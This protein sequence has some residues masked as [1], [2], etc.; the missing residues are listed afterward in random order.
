MCCYQ[1]EGRPPIP[2][3]PVP[4][5]GVSPIAPPSGSRAGSS[6]PWAPVTTTIVAATVLVFVASELLCYALPSYG[7]LLVSV[8]ANSPYRVVHDAWIWQLLSAGFMH[9]SS[10]HLLVNMFLIYWLAPP[11][12]NRLGGDLFLCLYLGACVFAY[13]FFDIYGLLFSTWNQTVGASGCTLAV[14]ST[15]AACFP[16]RTVDLFG[17]LRVRLWW[18]IALFVLSDVSV[19]LG[20]GGLYGANSIV[21]LGGVT[22][23][24]AFS[25]WI[26]RSSAAKTPHGS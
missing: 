19:V 12:E 2:Q 9:N 25:L 1:P 23:G 11:V 10:L 6:S 3:T 16:G 8:L 7:A 15:H 18:I 17:F 13:A 26:R 22:F 5:C 4:F 24:V 14:A 21:H 20:W